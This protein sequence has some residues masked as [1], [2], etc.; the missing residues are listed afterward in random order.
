MSSSYYS[1]TYS[2]QNATTTTTGLTLDVGDATQAG[3]PPVLIGVLSTGTITVLIEGSHDNSS[4]IDFSGGG[5]TASFAKDL[6]IGVRFWRTRITAIG[7]GGGFTS[8]VGTVPK[9]GGG[10]VNVRNPVIINNATAGQ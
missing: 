9:C 5:L 4:W 8:S 6:V 7:G 2:H 10:V 1:P 3:A